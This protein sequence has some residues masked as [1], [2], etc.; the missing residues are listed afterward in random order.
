MKIPTIGGLEQEKV[1][2]FVVSNDK[3]PLL[4]GQTVL[5]RLGKVELDYEKSGLE[6][7]NKEKVDKET[8]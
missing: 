2:A 1:R 6:D 5:N 3:A 8:L 4:L 7:Y